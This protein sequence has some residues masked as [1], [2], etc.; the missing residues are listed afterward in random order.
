MNYLCRDRMVRV[1]RVRARSSWR[2][3]QP[4]AHRGANEES[5]GDYAGDAD[6]THRFN[7]VLR[8]TQPVD[9]SPDA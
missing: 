3:V 4:T 8:Q 2:C 7:V 6:V 9:E 5:S 1:L